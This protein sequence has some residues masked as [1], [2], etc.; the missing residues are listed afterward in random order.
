MLILMLPQLF[1]KSYKEERVENLAKEVKVLV[2][3]IFLLK[4]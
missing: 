1:S 4:V 2:S 3:L